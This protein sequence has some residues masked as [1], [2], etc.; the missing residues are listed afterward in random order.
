MHAIRRWAMGGESQVFFALGPKG[1]VEGLATAGDRCWGWEAGEIHGREFLDFIAPGDRDRILRMIREVLSGK[2]SLSTEARF[3]GKDG[4]ARPLVCGLAA[5][6]GRETVLGFT[7]EFFPR[8]EEDPRTQAALKELKDFKWALDQHAIVAVTDDRGKITYVND[9][10]CDI[11]K[12]PRE[13][14]LGQDHRIIN[15]G[16]HPKAF[17]RDLWTTIKGGNVWKGEIKNKAKDGSP[18]WVDTTI[19]PLLDDEGHPIQFVAIRADITARKNGEEAQRQTQKLESLGVLAGGI[20]HD[21]NNLLTSILGNCNL[22][23]LSLPPGSPTQSFL[24]QIE[25]GSLRAADLTRQMLAYAG[26]GKTVIAPVNLNRLVTDMAKLLSISISKRA[27]IHCDLAPQVPDIT[28]DPTQMQQ[29]VMNLVTNA[30]DAVA[31][32][33]GGVIT[34][35]TGDRT[36]DA[37]DISSLAP[38]NPIKPGRYVTLEVSDNGCGMAPGTI[39]KIFDPFFT[40]KFTGRGLGLSALLGILLSHGG[41]IKVYSEVGHG[42]CMKV[43]L[44][45]AESQEPVPEADPVLASGELQGTVLVVDDDADARA[46]A[47]AFSGT[48]G[49][50]VLEAHD[51]LEAV[52]TFALRQREITLVLL[53]LTMPVMD[54]KEA[55]Q[56]IREI[57]AAVPIILSSGY[58]ER[59]A[60]G[61]MEGSG[62]A[63]F[64][65][66]PYQHHQF[67]AVIRGALVPR[68][69]A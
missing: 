47:R 53:D 31:E 16:H 5:K 19:V 15:S 11:S 42:T 43:F 49:L 60:V 37:L 48:L 17:F 1:I 10:F 25:Q 21:F 6:S 4:L 46:I 39:D 69:P 56:R 3:Q 36:I 12:Y 45:V 38:I 29:V 62:L 22:A 61:D 44:P 55:F 41:T 50:K 35:R 33:P 30:S 9:Y 59:E 27:T 13:E 67:E 23:S 58:N 57:S 40:T 68:E 18:Y 26:K 7:R 64:L 52:N 28:A 66:K 8:E 51:G 20:A 2:E 32:H 34:L 63:G 65:P 24:D 14:L 54:G